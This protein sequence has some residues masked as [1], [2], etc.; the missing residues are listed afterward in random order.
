MKTVELTEASR[1]LSQV[2]EEAQGEPVVVTRG[3]KPVAAVVP[4]GEV[5]LES[6]SLGTNSE[7]LALIERSRA[8]CRPG[9]GISSDEMRDRLT[10]RRKRASPPEAHGSR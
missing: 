9:E 6:L 8:R 4:I 10:A 7:F 2:A 3:G 5:D 1:S